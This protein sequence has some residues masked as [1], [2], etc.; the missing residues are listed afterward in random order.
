M[1][2]RAQIK[3]ARI[4]PRKVAIVLDLIRNKPVDVALAI[5]K[6]TP[7][8]ACEYLEKLLE[9]AISNAENNNNMERSSL[10]VDECYVCPGPI[11]KRIRPRAHGRAYRINKR[12]S[13]ITLVLREKE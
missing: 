7:K 5:L 1:E 13:H 2:A 11:L 12:T 3:Y 10:Y 6:N 8:A 9:S 4:S